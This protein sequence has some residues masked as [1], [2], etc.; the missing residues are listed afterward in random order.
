MLPEP[1]RRRVLDAVALIAEVEGYHTV[2][3]DL[4]ALLESGRI[5]FWPALTDRAHAGLTRRITLGPEAVEGGVVG[6]AE[7]LVHEHWHLF[8][9][10]PLHK[11]ASFW[12]GVATGTPVMARFERPA[13]RAAFDFLEA[14]AR[15]RPET[16]A[17]AR[18]EAQAIAVAF[19]QEYGGSLA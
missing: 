6:L 16:E 11:T 8:R 14:L 4:A 7:T 9:Q 18:A 2:A 12:A 15:Q 17:I 13:Y 19:E 1:H 10:I 3:Q 5:R